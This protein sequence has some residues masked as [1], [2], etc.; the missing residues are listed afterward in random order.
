MSAL[1]SGLDS[2]IVNMESDESGF[3]EVSLSLVKANPYQPRKEF[4]E[5]SIAEL[6]E[7]IKS[8]GVIQPIL[9]EESLNGGYTIIAGERR[10]RASKL[11]GLT[12]IP[13]IVKNISE[14]EKLEISLVENIQ[15]EDLTAI[16]EA[17]A[18]KKLMD[19]L[20]LN[21]EEVAH[22]VGKKRSTIS[23]SIRLLNLPDDLQQSVNIGELSAGHARALLSIDKPNIQRSIFNKIKENKLSVRATEKM[24][25]DYSSEK[26]EIKH[27]NKRIDPDIQYI[28]Q[29]FIDALGTK[30][31]L[32]G[33]I[34]KGTV[35]VT[36]FSKDDL[37]RIVD[38]LS[39]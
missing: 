27:I 10:Y 21:Q 4:S 6:S 36:Y 8:C 14:E 28:E 15:R 23:N 9:V 38:L 33:N 31:K 13:V 24:V 34:E 2:L 35:E 18:Y 37:N 17:K 11:A 16:E 39:K 7:S 3:N 20:K 32:K 26:K 25:S 19:S 29:L 1:G 30:V 5:E 22:K 12:T